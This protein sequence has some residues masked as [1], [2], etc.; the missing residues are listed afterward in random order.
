MKIE[1]FGTGC[2][3]CKR[4]YTQVQEIIKE[5][6]L[7]VE[8]T[9]FDG[10]QAMNKIIELGVMGSPVLLINDQIVLVGGADK[11]KLTELIMEK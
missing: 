3:T 4:M 6:N 2:P 9:Y 5:N 8:A 10:D 11:K 7:P 1:V